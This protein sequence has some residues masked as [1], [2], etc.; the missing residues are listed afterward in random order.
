MKQNNEIT[1]RIKGNIKDFY[2][3]IEEKGFKIIDKFSMDDTYFI[4][5][6]LNINNIETREI[7]SKAVLIRDIRGKMSNRVTKK[8]TF[9]VKN[10]DEYGNILSQESINCDVLEID[11]AK[12]L[13]AAIG[14]KEIMNIKEDDVVYEKNGFQFA[15]KD[16]LNG[17]NLIEVETKDD[18]S[19]DTIEKLM[20]RVDEEDIPIYKDDYFVKK[21]E[22]EL[23]KILKR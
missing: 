2:K 3:L 13:L 4:P 18:E 22:I 5:A 8:I 23:N 15:V 16:I 9:K 12:R 6:N 21:A 10:F 17:D 19:L 11:D 14:Y 7:L 20:K 1:V